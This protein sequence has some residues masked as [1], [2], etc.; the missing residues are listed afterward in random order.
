MKN[1]K[2]Y[3]NKTA[4]EW[5]KEWYENETMLPCLKVFMSMLKKNPRIL[6]L[7]CGAGYESMRMHQLGADVVGLDFSKESIKIARDKN[8]GIQF[9]IGN[10][11]EDYS[12]I[13]QVDG[14]TVIAGFVHLSNNDLRTAFTQAATILRNEGLMLVVI[15]EGIGKREKQS[16][17]TIEGEEYDRE[18]Y[19]HTL[20]ELV[21]NSSDV[22]KF[23]EEILPDENDFWKKYI[24]MKV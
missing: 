24:F 23:V 21:E 17:I 10:M 6:D 11:L 2:D 15:R 5:A 20:D 16:Y 19:A 3:Y 14:I 7:C 1:T 8:P 9:H 13:N 12:Y 18:F 4:E 22:F